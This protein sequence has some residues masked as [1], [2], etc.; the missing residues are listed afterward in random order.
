M[1]LQ[2]K[3]QKLIL[4]GK[5]FQVPKWYLNKKSLLKITYWADKEVKIGTYVKQYLKRL[6]RA[7]E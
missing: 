2:S 6:K 5:Y 1:Y 7:N 4:I 3:L